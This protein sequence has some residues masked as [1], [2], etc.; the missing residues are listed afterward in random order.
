MPTWL[1]LA[2]T[3]VALVGGPSGVVWA[4]Y[5]GTRTPPVPAVQASDPTTLTIDSLGLRGVGVLPMA[6]KHGALNPPDNPRLVGWWNQS[7][8]AGAATGTTLLTAHK[9]HSGSAVFEHLVELKPGAT[10]VV[11]GASGSYAYVVQ[12]VRVLTKDR[13]AAEAG[14]LFSQDGPHRLLLV[15]C[16]DWDGKEFASNSV[17][18]AVPA[19]VVPPST[20]GSSRR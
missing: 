15:T 2:V 9:V 6:L 14:R 13:M 8:D 4:A 17:V 1:I 5:L 16:E 20:P 7:A 19:P 12:D 11:G 3:L 10:V 18:T